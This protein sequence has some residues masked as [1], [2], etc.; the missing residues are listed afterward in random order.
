MA[1]KLYE[2][3]RINIKDIDANS[4]NRIYL[5][6]KPDQ[7]S[8]N[9]IEP[10][11][12]LKTTKAL[13]KSKIFIAESELIR[14]LI[15][16]NPKNAETD[17]SEYPFVRDLIILKV[18]RGHKGYEALKQSE[19][20]PESGII[21]VNDIKYKR[22]ICASGHNRA[23]KAMFIKEELFEKVNDILLCGIPKDKP[24]APISKYNA[25]YGLPATD[26]IPVSLPN[27]VVVDDFEKAITQKY[28]VVYGDVTKPITEIRGKR[29]PETEVVGH[30]EY[31]VENDVLKEVMIKPF[32][33]AGLIDAQKAKEWSKELGLDYI[34]AS[35]Q[36]RCILGIKG[37]LFVFDIREFAKTYG[38][39]TITDI[40]GKVWDIEDDHIDCI[41]TK[42]QFKF[43]KLYD[44]YQEWLDNFNKDL[45]GYHRTF[46]VS[47]YSD[48]YTKPNKDS[49]S[50]ALRNTA[51]MCYQPLQTLRFTN[52][53][54]ESL[55]QRTV[56]NINKIHTD[57]G[58][59]LRYRGITDEDKIKWSKVPPYYK[60]LKYN[61]SLFNDPYI[62]KKVIED[63]KS[64]KLKSYVGK[65]IVDANYQTLTPDIFG[66]A[67][68]AFGLEPVGL[69]EAD[70]VYSYYWCK[71][72][73][74]ELDLIRSPHIANEHCPVK[75]TNNAY[76]QDW[77]RYQDT[78]YIT[79]MH[80]T[81]LLKM[82][83]ADTDGDH[84]LG[85]AD[86]DIISAA[87]GCITNTIDFVR[88]DEGRKQ[89]EFL[90]NDTNR[91]IDTDVLGFQNN[92]GEV[93]NKISILWSLPQTPGVQDAIKIMSIIGSLT[94]DFVK[95]GEKA[96]IP[97]DILDM[98]KR[99]KRP[100]F[101]QYLDK[102][103]ANKEKTIKKN[104]K[105]FGLTVDDKASNY[106]N[107][108]GDTDC[109]MNKI[110][111]YMEKQIGEIK[112]EI[113]EEKF[114][115]SSLLRTDVN[116]YNETYKKV[117]QKLLE[118]QEEQYDINNKKYHSMDDSEDEKQDYHNKYQQFYAYA[119]TELIY[120]CRD[121]DKLV[122]YLITIFYSD[123]D[124]VTKA[125]RAIL[126]NCFYGQMI[127]RCR[128]KKSK[129]E[130]SI[131]F[132][133]LEKRRQKN[134]KNIAK[135]KRE[136]C[137]VRISFLENKP[138]VRISKENIS[139]IKKVINIPKA[140][141]NKT[142]KYYEEARRLFFVLL[143]I[144]RKL[145][146]PITIFEAKKNQINYSQLN[147]LADI[148]GRHFQ[149]I[150]KILEEAGVIQVNTRNL[151]APKI[152]VVFDSVDGKS[153][154]ICIDNINEC[155]SVLNRHFPYSKYKN[156][157]A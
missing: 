136:K 3:I 22:L 139:Q 137:L 133:A 99:Y 144:Y 62:N 45:H 154:D 35:F 42:S 106:F 134:I 19:H 119:K 37:N 17:G 49:K 153:S 94:I 7:D 80:D 82:N 15:A 135:S 57:V 150:I 147:K 132:D 112:P 59:F 109:T 121:I 70:E 1:N 88:L 130:N 6:E 102:N 53:E 65:L 38:V 143:V 155:K 30:G 56:E 101:M 114:D 103:A 50:K 116:I 128:G 93:I 71:K 55:C 4:F 63:L 58:Q 20:N 73:I 138:D 152:T 2:V 149:I 113:V 156:K 87:K 21:Y 39:R 100:Y 60:A 151:A 74:T 81:C 11:N 69:L 141:D 97:K 31:H 123:K 47:E 115:Y 64:I 90:I 9:P 124:F 24:Y 72:G 52:D 28:D 40:W 79:S 91:L 126:W 122:E 96:D 44:S 129:K 68:Y 120:F 46:N 92:I 10:D 27:I 36:F 110:C 95:T 18:G 107:K 67:Q 25:Y 29:N 140:K 98:I 145:N 142:K 75:V 84:V 61:Y 34:P 66:L 125:D 5:L 16:L 105:R 78:G 14:I 118:L 111:K 131:D 117:K 12:E 33:G 13:Q 157:V 51:L 89:E 104:I 127:N 41:M 108:F 32:D 43:Y 77:Y 48:A 148:D 146:S 26:S 85:V 83:S 8:S 86:K 23:K 54:I 76:M